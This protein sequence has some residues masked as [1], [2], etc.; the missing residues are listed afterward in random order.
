MNKILIFNIGNVLVNYNLNKISSRLAALSQHNQAELHKFIFN[1]LTYL[2]N[3]GVIS[4]QDFYEKINFRFSIYIT[5][6]EF[7]KIWCD[8]IIESGSVLIIAKH[9]AEKCKLGVLAYTNELHFEFLVKNIPFFNIFEDHHLSYKIKMTPSDEEVFDKII[10]FYN[11]NPEYI[12]YVDDIIENVY[13]ARKY[14]LNG[15]RFE[16]A[17]QLFRELNKLGLV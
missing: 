12:T 10:A 5:F 13:N 2:F 11:C 15:I 4:G 16:G 9:A 14:G 8:N 7:K 17:D 3:K 6:D 1:G